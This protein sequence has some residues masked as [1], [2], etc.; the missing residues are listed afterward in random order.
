MDELDA[1]IIGELQ[2]DARLSNRELARLIG[3]SPSTCLERVRSLT[4]RGVIRGYHADIDPVALNRGVQAM[5]SVQVR[6][7]DR[8]VIDKFKAAAT[9]MPEVLNVFVLAG[10][11]DFLLHI[12]VPDLDAMHG[13]LLDR[14]SK[15]REVTNFRT[16]V[17]FQQVANPAPGLIVS[18]R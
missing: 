1:R 14:L 5:I 6:P 18:P 12:G 7:L 16:S 8:D 13:F 17:I 10:G 2:S 4:R 9:R 3:V 15:R 11:D